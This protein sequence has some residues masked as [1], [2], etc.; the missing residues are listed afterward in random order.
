MGVKGNERNPRASGDRECVDTRA[1][2]SVDV[3]SHV[4]GGYIGDRIVVGRDTDVVVL[5]LINLKMYIN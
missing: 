2:K 4:S 5:A 3:A 1:G